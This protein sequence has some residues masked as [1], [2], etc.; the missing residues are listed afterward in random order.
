MK[1]FVFKKNLPPT[2]MAEDEVKK[3]GKKLAKFNSDEQ[4]VGLIMYSFRNYYVVC[5]PCYFAECTL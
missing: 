4:N 5:Y 3:I 1:N 2:R